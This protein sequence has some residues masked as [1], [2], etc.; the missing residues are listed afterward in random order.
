MYSKP[1]PVHPHNGNVFCQWF[2]PHLFRSPPFSVCSCL[3]LHV[4]QQA[5][6]CDLSRNE[7]GELYRGRGRVFSHGQLPMGHA[8]PIALPV[9]RHNDAL[10]EESTGQEER[11]GWPPLCCF[12]LCKNNHLRPPPPTHTHT[13]VPCLYK[14]TTTLLHC[15][16]AAK[17]TSENFFAPYMNFSVRPLENFLAAVSA[18]SSESQSVLFVRKRGFYTCPQISNLLTYR[19][20]FHTSFLTSPFNH[21]Q[22]YLLHARVDC[23]NKRA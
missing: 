13:H 7:A 3:W 20:R 23:Q 16:S 17:D 1:L 2:L 6:L 9:S 21:C 22:F 8:S 12:F 4:H 18:S 11:V 19:A 15:G 10:G 5:V 14:Y